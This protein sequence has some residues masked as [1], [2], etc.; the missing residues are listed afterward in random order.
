MATES[1]QD[2]F[3][4]AV[5]HEFVGISNEYMSQAK[6]FARLH[7]L[8]KV[9]PTGSVIVKDGIV[10]GKA[11]NGSSYHETHICERVHLKIPTGQGYELC[12]GCHPKN[13]SEVRAVAD[14]LSKGI[15]LQ[16]A[17][18]YLWGHWWLCRWC[19]DSLSKV[20]IQ[21]IFLLERSEILF[22]KTKNGNI[23]G[24]QFQDK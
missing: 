19:R 16:G 23:V 12:E 10:L 5:M 13:H 2:F 9:M 22:N 17:E 7:S 1:D 8:D 3:S 6:E 24:R 4:K 21:K 18:I 20:G 11:A 15:D 14:A